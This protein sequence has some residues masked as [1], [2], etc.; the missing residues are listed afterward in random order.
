[1][2]RIIAAALG[3]AISVWAGATPLPGAVAESVDAPALA[4]PSELALLAAA[5]RSLYSQALS[6]LASRLANYPEDYEASLL[7]SLVLFKSGEWRE[8]FEELRSLTRRAP[9]FHLAH[10]IHGD[11]LLAQARPVT[12]IGAG[13][14]MAGLSDGG[15]MPLR[16]E[17]EV[18]LKAYLD[19]IPGGRLPRPLLALGARSEMAIVVDKRV[20]RL[21]V[22]RTEPGAVMPRLVQD[23]YVST[24]KLDGNKQSSGDLRTPEGVY[25]VTGHIP[26][27]KLPEKYGIGAFPLD[28]P[29]ALDR[30]QGKT[31]YGIWLHGTDD[32]YY[33]RPPLDSEGCVVLPNIDLRAVSAYL[34][35]GTPVVIADGVEWLEQEQWLRLRNELL[36]AVE[37]WRADWEGRDVERYLGHYATDFWSGASDL[38]RWSRHKRAVFQGKSFQQVRL[39]ELSVFAYPSDATGRE[40]ALV[41]FRQDYR[42]NNFNSRMAKQ[43]YLVKEAGVWRILH[44]GAP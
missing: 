34:E 9:N 39:E 31:G 8:A 36:K 26:G 29:N 27:E 18:R 22:Y 43:L 11:L 3:L 23:F 14:R 17:A 12:G 24:G 1:M 25:F 19:T 15:I 37:T 5:D 16:S 32:L 7:K 42:S 40:L 20:H 30:R 4:A 21:Y 44:E 33:S 38:G 2:R 6:R 28:Y 35:P 13:P 41:R 10:L